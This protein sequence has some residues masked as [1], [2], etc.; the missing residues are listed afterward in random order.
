MERYYDLGDD[1]IA[2]LNE[3]ISKFVQTP[4]RVDYAFIG[5]NKLK[6]LVKVSKISDVNK[7]LMKGKQVLVTVNEA[8]WDAISEK[9]DVIEILVREEFNGLVINTETNKI[10]IEKLTF[11]SS[12]SII[13]KYTF[14]LVREAKDLEKCALEQA[15]EKEKEMVDI[16]M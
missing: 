2:K 1:T 4:V 14:D 10:K 3:L 11:V 6:K 7:H 9:E 15:D 13:E 12:N 5:D 8:L 16:S